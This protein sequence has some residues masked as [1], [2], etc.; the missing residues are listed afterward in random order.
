MIFLQVKLLYGAIFLDSKLGSFFFPPVTVFILRAKRWEKIILKFNLKKNRILIAVFSFIIFNF[1]G[2]IKKVFRSWR[3]VIIW[4]L[5][6]N[7][8]LQLL[9]NPMNFPKTATWRKCCAQLSFKIMYKLKKS[10]AP[11]FYNIVKNQKIFTSDSR[12][13]TVAGR[14]ADLQWFA[15]WH[16]SLTTKDHKAKWHINTFIDQNLLRCFLVN[17]EIFSASS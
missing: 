7:F 14:F 10:L 8:P 12:V 2:K 11:S 5:P 3:K 13:I 1:V 15:D 16:T 9:I 17:L 6:N 4:P